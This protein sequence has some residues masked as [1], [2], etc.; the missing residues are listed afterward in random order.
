MSM[1]NRRGARSDGY[2]VA[3]YGGPRL[4]ERVTCLDALRRPD[5]YP[6]SAAYDPQWMVDH[7]MGPNPLWLLEDLTRD[8]QLRP[9]MKVL[10][11][12]CGMGMTSVFLVREYGVQVWAAEHWL[13]A[14]DNAARFRAAGVD[15]QV[16]A[17]ATSAK[18]VDPARP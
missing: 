8:C 13:P 5:V 10:D 7:R 18:W 9:G 16:H 17:V 6:R 11:L 2:P 14:D 12:G 15:G 3:T 4:C 1:A